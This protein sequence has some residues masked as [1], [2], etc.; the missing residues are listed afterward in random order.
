MSVGMQLSVLCSEDA[1][2]VTPGDVEQ[3]SAGTLFGLHLLSSQLKACEIWPRG[4]V[5]A[6][7]FEPVVS[8]VPALVLSGDLD[9]VTPPAWGDAV[10]KSLENGRHITVPGTGHGVIA[11]VCGQRLIQDFLDRASSEL[12]DITCVKSIKRPP[13]FVSPAGPDP[14]HTTGS[15]PGQD[16]DR[17]GPGPGQAP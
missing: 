12:L 5:D 3:A 17:T 9:P 10:V 7:Y 16:G 2:R 6:S 1:A 11:T 15:G 8:D 13:F 4:A 14:A